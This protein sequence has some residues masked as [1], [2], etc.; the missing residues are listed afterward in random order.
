M[1]REMSGS[2]VQPPLDHPSSTS[3]SGGLSGS[4]ASTNFE[5]GIEMELK[6]MNISLADEKNQVNTNNS[7]P[8]LQQD[9]AE[10]QRLLNENI[11]LRGTGTHIKYRKLI[12]AP[13]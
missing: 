5:A 8:Y 2:P 10:N 11:L 6:D 13:S 1:Y 4:V 9:R 7:D 3:T 12:V